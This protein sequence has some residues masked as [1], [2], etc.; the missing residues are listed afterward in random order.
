MFHATS[1]IPWLTTRVFLS[2]EKLY[3]ALFFVDSKHPSSAVLLFDIGMEEYHTVY[4]DD[5][6]RDEA[7]TERAWTRYQRENKK[8]IHKLFSGKRLIFSTTASYFCHGDWYSFPKEMITAYFDFLKRASSDDNVAPA[9]MEEMLVDEKY[10]PLMCRYTIVGDEEYYTFYS[11]HLR[12]GLSSSS[13]ST[14]TADYNT[15]DSILLY[16]ALLK[17]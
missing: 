13:F 4:I 17:E 11:E 1:V 7:D 2:Q 15:W 9:S 10:L 5:T 12:G 14:T 8:K 3:P 6:T 16:T